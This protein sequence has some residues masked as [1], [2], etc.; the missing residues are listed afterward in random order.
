VKDVKEEQTCGKGLAE[1]SPLPGKL[2]ELTGAMAGILETHREALELRDASSRREDEAYRELAEAHRKIAGELRETS[3][4]MAGY[5]D[6]PMG[7]HDPGAMSSSKAV[8]AVERF[9]N[10]EAELAA[11]LQRRLEADRVMLEQMRGS[12]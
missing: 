10:V 2:S 1:N 11:M 6:L 5:R 9:V 4:I 12:G 3:R 8:Q 7:K